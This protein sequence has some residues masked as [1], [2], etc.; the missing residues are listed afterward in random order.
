M[1][2]LRDTWGLQLKY[3]RTWL[4]YSVRLR[5]PHKVEDLQTSR[6]P[7][8]SQPTVVQDYRGTRGNQ[9]SSTP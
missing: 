9:K 2:L 5:N 8:Q 4:G 3:S 1:A 6:G 7:K